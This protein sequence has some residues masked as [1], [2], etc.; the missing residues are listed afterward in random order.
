MPATG[1]NRPV[2]GRLRAGVRMWRRPARAKR[3]PVWWPQA[4]ELL[5]QGHSLKS[6]GERVGVSSQRVAQIAVKAESFGETVRRRRQNPPQPRPCAQCGTVFRPHSDKAA[7]C[8]RQCAGRGRSAKTRPAE[9]VRRAYE[10]RCAG[11][12]FW[13]IAETL[14]ISPDGPRQYR[15]TRARHFAQVWARQNGLVLPGKPRKPRSPG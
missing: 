13:E 3:L 9:T 5:E 7:Y 14:N 10:L 8:S 4:K 6:V 15:Q 1:D 11:K 2:G 12:S